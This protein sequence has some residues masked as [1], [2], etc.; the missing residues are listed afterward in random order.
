MS[1]ALRNLIHRSA[2]DES[3]LEELQES[4][5]EGSSPDEKALDPEEREALF[6]V[7]DLLYLPFMAHTGPK[8]WRE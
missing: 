6:S 5:A 8:K 4:S 3:L 7:K 2:T 1:K